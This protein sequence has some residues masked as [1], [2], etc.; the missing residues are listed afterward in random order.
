MSKFRVPTEAALEAAADCGLSDVVII[1]RDIDD[2]ICIWS[3]VSSAET[4]DLIEEGVEEAQ[5]QA[6]NEERDAGDEADED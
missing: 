6:L 1:G 3:S 5:A 2:E 4:F